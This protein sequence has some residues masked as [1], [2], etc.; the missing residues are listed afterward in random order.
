[1]GQDDAHAVL[2]GGVGQGSFPQV[3]HATFLFLSVRT[4]SPPA[5]LT[6]PWTS[7]PSRSMYSASWLEHLQQRMPPP[8]NMRTEVSNIL[9][10]ICMQ[11]GL[12]CVPHYLPHARSRH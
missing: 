12:F 4:M 8:L 10:T 9:S 11:S 7:V 2:P 1:M 3:S 5:L 6:Y